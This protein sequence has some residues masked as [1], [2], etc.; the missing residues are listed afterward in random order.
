MEVPDGRLNARKIIDVV[1][2]L[3]V[4][5]APSLMK[6]RLSMMSAVVGNWSHV[7]RGCSRY[8]LLRRRVSV[9]SFWTSA[10]SDILHSFSRGHLYPFRTASSV[11]SFSFFPS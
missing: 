1:D 10:T 6:W 3:E 4:A 8:S 2:A 5:G 7:L 9:F 11:I